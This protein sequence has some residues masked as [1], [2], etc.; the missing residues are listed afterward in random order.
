MKEAVKTNQLFIRSQNFDN[1]TELLIM[2]EF[3]TL[4]NLKDMLV[5]YEK[6]LKQTQ[7]FSALNKD[8]LEENTRLK[9]RINELSNEIDEMR[10][11]SDPE[12]QDLLLK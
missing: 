8:I 5:N 9:L 7:E 6:C 2:K 4:V 1:D 11:K 12:E 10:L 3:D